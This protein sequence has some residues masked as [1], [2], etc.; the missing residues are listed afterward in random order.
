MI[1][2][3]RFGKASRAAGLTGPPRRR[4]SLP[5][6]YALI[7]ALSLPGGRIDA[8]GTA[9]AWTAWACQKRL[10]LSP[11]GDGGDERQASYSRCAV[12]FRFIGP[13]LSNNDGCAVARSDEAKAL[14]IEMG[15]PLFKIRDIVSRHRVRVLSSNYELYGDMAARV[16]AT[17]RQFVP[18]EPYSRLVSVSTHRRFCLRISCACEMW[19]SAASQ[20]WQ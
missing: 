10:P 6:S 3:N 16:L 2:T 1:S 17:V 18:A 19:L 12:A 13:V 7:M 9:P 15:V 20:R 5:A 11:F 8:I 14:G 4:Y